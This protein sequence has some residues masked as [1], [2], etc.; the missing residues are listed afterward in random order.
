MIDNQILTHKEI[1]L[2]QQK[3]ICLMM[4]YDI[5]KQELNSIYYSNTLDEIIGKK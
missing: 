4:Y 3:I 2:L 5:N 1:Y